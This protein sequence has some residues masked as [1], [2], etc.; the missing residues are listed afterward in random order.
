MRSMAPGKGVRDGRGYMAF[1]GRG[2]CSFSVILSFQ[3][4][5]RADRANKLNDEARD[6]IKGPLHS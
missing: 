4:I 3:F 2:S 1:V 6:C 5:S